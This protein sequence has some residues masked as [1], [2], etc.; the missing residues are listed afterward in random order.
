MPIA[1]RKS[2]K[3]KAALKDLETYLVKE[4]NN[5]EVV[6]DSAETSHQNELEDL[7]EQQ[8]D[9]LKWAKK[10]F[11]DG[12]SKEKEALRTCRSLKKS[13][14]TKCGEAEKQNA[15]LHESSKHIKSENVQL[16]EALDVGKEEWQ[17]KRKRMYKA[18]IE[19]QVDSYL[20]EAENERLRGDY[21]VDPVRKSQWKKLI[22]NKDTWNKRLQ[23]QHAEDLEKIYRLQVT[24]RITT[25]AAKEQMEALAV[26]N[27]SYKKLVQDLMSNKQQCRET[28][29]KMLGMLRGGF[30]LQLDD[31]FDAVIKRSNI[32]E[33]DNIKL[34]ANFDATLAKLW[35]NTEATHSRQKRKWHFESEFAR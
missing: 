3:L 11:D 24:V 13:L 23:R 35:G 2:R 29:E 20:R 1:R 16:W 30:I 5:F 19:A 21:D 7:K 17:L 27:V 18:R 10:D 14:E 31:G 22:E 34:L 32:L 4:E 12:L 8:A 6:I 25:E 26:Q 28:N 9:E 15:N 33:K